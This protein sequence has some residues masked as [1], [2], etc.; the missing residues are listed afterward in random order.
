MHRFFSKTYGNRATR[1]GLGQTQDGRGKLWAHDWF[2]KLLDLNRKIGNP[3]EEYTRLYK[4]T[5]GEIEARD[6]ANRRELTAEERR[7]KAPD[8]GDENTVFAEDG[9]YFSMSAEERDGIAEQLKRNQEALNNLKVVAA[10]NSTKFVGLST[11]EARTA[12]VEELRRTGYQV[13]RPG[14]GKITFTPSEINESLNY[15]QKS[16]E[17]EDARRLGFLVLKDVLKRG[18]VIQ[19]HGQHKGRNYDTITIAAPV[20]ING[21]RVNMAAVVKQTKGNKYKVHRIF[22]TDGISFSLKKTADAEM[23]TARAFTNGSQSLGGS[24]LTI[25]SASKTS[26]RQEGQKSQEVFSKNRASLEE[27]ADE[28]TDKANRYRWRIELGNARWRPTRSA[29]R[30]TKRLTR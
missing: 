24:A 5:A 27:I 26:I 14:M 21:E 17:V 6:V 30:S 12:I 4:N 15:K 8:L 10:V 20:E 28:A 9:N 22:T 23:N 18:I 25:N 2:R 16:R 3:G 1:R 11:G 13:D 29:A 19:E 7:K